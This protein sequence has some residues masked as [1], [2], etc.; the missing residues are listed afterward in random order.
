MMGYDQEERY[1]TVAVI[2]PVNVITTEAARTQLA[3]HLL[4]DAVAHET[5]KFDSIGR[6][7]D[8]FEH[9]FPSGDD[10]ALTELRIA[11]TF[12]DAWI[13]ARNHGWQL[14][15]GIQPADWPVLAREIAADLSAER[16]I[17]DDRIRRAFDASRHMNLADRV[18]ILA[19]RLRE[20]T[21]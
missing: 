19:S 1:R 16:P 3:A 5:G 7:F 6:R 9:A 21:R 14:T 12:W 8:S 15:A 4:T 13:D 20:R 18:N 10:D 17:A 2:N 11:L